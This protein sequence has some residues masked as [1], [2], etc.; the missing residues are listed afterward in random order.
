MTAIFDHLIELHQAGMHDFGKRPEFA[1]EHPQFCGFR[2]VEELERKSDFL[3]PVE[4]LEYRSKSSGSEFPNHLKAGI[5]AK[6]CLTCGRAGR[7][8]VFGNGRTLFEECREPVMFPEHFHY[9]GEQKLV[10]AALPLHERYTVFQ[11]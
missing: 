8:G 10:L 11:G 6:L 7:A 2:A 4:C 5:A 9:C 3:P 1:L